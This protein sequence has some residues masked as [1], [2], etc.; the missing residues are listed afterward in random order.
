VGIAR[1]R[2][3]ESV[4]VIPRSTS[5]LV[6]ALHGKAAMAR[7]ESSMMGMVSSYEREE[8]RGGRGGGE[9]LG[10]RLPP[11]H[12]GEEGGVPRGKEWSSPCC[13]V[14]PTVAPSLLLA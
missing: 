12:Y 9:E 7:L 4:L 14:L 3:C 11:G 5:G 8:R 1:G 6:E 2:L 10:A 13:F